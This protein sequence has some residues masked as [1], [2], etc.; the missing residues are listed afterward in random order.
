MDYLHR[1]QNVVDAIVEN[2]VQVLAFGIEKPESEFT[3][4]ILLKHYNTY[5]S[6][7]DIQAVFHEA[8]KRAPLRVDCWHNRQLDR[9]TT[10]NYRDFSDQQIQWRSPYLKY[11]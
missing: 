1:K 8:S 10:Q 3:F 7:L 2:I 9:I 5:H 6:N 4:T 11:P